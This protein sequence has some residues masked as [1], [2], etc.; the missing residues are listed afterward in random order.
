[1]EKRVKISVVIPIYNS[2]EYLRECLDSIVNQ[3]LQ[4]FEVICVNDGSTDASLDILKEYEARDSRFVVVSQKNQGQSV[5]RNNGMQMAQGEYILFVD[6]D[7]LLELNAMEYLWNGVSAQDLDVLYFDAKTIYENQELA[8]QKKSMREY[9]SRKDVYREIVTGPELFAKMRRDDA[10]RVQP[11]LQL[12]RRSLLLESGVTFP[13]GIIHEDNLFTT[14]LM[15]SAARV[16][17]HSKAFYTRRVR[18]ESTM[19]N[20]EKFKNLYGYFLCAV[21]L[22]EYADKNGLMDWEPLRKFIEEL[23]GDVLR[24]FKKLPSTEKSKICEVPADQQRVLVELLSRRHAMGAEKLVLK[25][26]VP[27]V[28]VVIPVYKVE[29]YLEK[30][31]DSVVGQSLR[32]IEIICVDDGSP[33]RCGEICHRYAKND[34]RIKVIHQE[35]QGL[36]AARNT[37]IEHATG[38]YIAFVD[39]DDWLHPNFLEVL[40][41]LCVDNACLISRCGLQKLYSEDEAVTEYRCDGEIV[42]GKDMIHRRFEANGWMQVVAWNKLYHR[43]VFSDIRYPHGKI[44]EDEFTTYRTYWKAEHVAYTDCKL[45]YYRQ[46]GDSIM[47]RGFNEKSLHVIEAYEESAEFFR[48]RD[49]WLY[50]KS[51]ISLASAIS[52]CR[53]NAETHCPDRKDL[54]DLLNRKWT[55]LQEVMR[56]N[57]VCVKNPPPDYAVFPAE[58]RNP[59]PVTHHYA[60]SGRYCDDTTQGEGVVTAGCKVSVV[61]PV[62]NTEKYLR[63]CLDSVLSQSIRDLEVICVNDGSPDN[64]LSILREY[65]KKDRRVVVLDQPNMGVFVARNRAMLCARGEFICF[66]D[67]DDFYPH[68]GTLEMLYRKAKEHNVLVCGGSFSNYCDGKVS[69]DF[70][71]ASR[72]Y[73]FDKEGL[74]QYRD[75]QFDYGYHRFLY[76]R[77]ML[78]DNHITFPPYKRF[79]DPPFFVKAMITAGSF[80]AVPEAVYRYRTGFQA[81][82]ASWP[83]D[84]LHDML[85]GYLDNLNLSREAGLSELHALTLQRIEDSYTFSP[86]MNVMLQ[87]DFEAMHLMIQINNALDAK[88]L[89]QAGVDLKGKDFY[90]VRELKNLIWR[91]NNANENTRSAIVLSDQMANEVELICSSWS[92]RIGRFMTFIPRKIRGG[93][94]CYKEHGMKYTLRRVKEKFLGL[95]NR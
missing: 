38:D 66:M 26:V 15:L 61:V 71:G 60:L 33:D 3:T 24:I 94:C 34:K 76:D 91:C 43:S 68:S 52:R 29:E 42:T 9:Y 41:R 83:L 44:H 85:R 88:L 75:Y 87:Y 77:N 35:N 55:A 64:S 93:I 32:D 11:C 89:K 49:Q 57:N 80:Y 20:V 10:Y 25:P 69:E 70:E 58:K 53:K 51:L 59:A 81:K 17:H 56:E 6:S 14:E 46:R 67:S 23:Q 4:D 12:I 65:E 86:V 62:Y 78:L 13:K 45:Y 16:A 28:S 1:M 72:K 47:G 27:K 37:G 90:I 84:K 21:G 30:C 50:R 22:S 5:A 79:Q 92:Y 18:D 54:K 73:K 2:S 8:E 40:Y 19:T 39:S 82:P 63:E 36:S 7:D 31:L 48:Q 74:M 95:F